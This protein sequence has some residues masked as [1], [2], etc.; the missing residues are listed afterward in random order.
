MLGLA[1]HRDAQVLAFACLTGRPVAAIGSTA[2]LSWVEHLDTRRI[3]FYGTRL[4]GYN[5]GELSFPFMCCGV[6]ITALRALRAQATRLGSVS[7]AVRA[8]RMAARYASRMVPDPFGCRSLQRGGTGRAIGLDRAEPAWTSRFRDSLVAISLLGSDV[9]GLPL[10]WG[11]RTC[12]LAR[13]GAALS[14]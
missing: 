13:D 1:A 5:R 10:L 8:P 3:I 7:R 2:T 12:S 6:N 11:F 9:R 14:R 4:L